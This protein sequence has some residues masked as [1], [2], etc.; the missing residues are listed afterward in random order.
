MDSV[1]RLTPTPCVAAQFDDTVCGRVVAHCRPSRDIR[2][3]QL[4]SL[5][6][7]FPILQSLDASGCDAMTGAWLRDLEHHT[8]IRCRPYVFLVP[9]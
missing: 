5:L 7:R 3:T 4:S 6:Q 8:T 2:D 9:L 1:Q